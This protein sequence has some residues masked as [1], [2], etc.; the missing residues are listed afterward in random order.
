MEVED[1]LKFGPT[2][3]DFIRELGRLITAR[4]G[5][6]RETAWLFQRLSIALQRG[7][8]AAILG[9]AATDRDRTNHT[10][11]PALPRNGAGST[12]GAPS[13][14]SLPETPANHPAGEG[15]S[16]GGGTSSN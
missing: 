12:N 1:D 16:T 3:S 15:P 6:Q 5:D 4:T 13:S 14:A 9:T 7:N 8:A 2:A 10:R 11:L